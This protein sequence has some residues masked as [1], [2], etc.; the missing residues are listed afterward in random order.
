M[1]SA[2]VHI[3][4]RDKDR[5]EGCNGAVRRRVDA[6]LH[7]ADLG[8]QCGGIAI[9]DGHTRQL[10][11]DLRTGLHHTVD[12]VDKQQHILLLLIPQVLRQCQA[13]VHGPAAAHGVVA[14]LAEGHGHLVQQIRLH[15]LVVQVAAL[16]GALTYTN[17]YGVGVQTLIH[18]VDQLLDQHR[19]AHAGAAQQ[20]HLEALAHRREKVQHLDACPQDIA[21]N[22]D[23]AHGQRLI[24]DVAGMGRVQRCSVQ[25]I[26]IGAEHVT[27]CLIVIGDLQSAR[28]QID[29]HPALKAACLSA[30]DRCRHGAI[31]LLHL[32]H[33]AHAAGLCIQQVAYADIRPLQEHLHLQA[34][35]RHNTSNHIIILLCRTVGGLHRLLCLPLLDQSLH[36]R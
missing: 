22:H 14:H 23:L 3:I 33:I 32:E 1:H 9:V 28:L 29:G 6:L 20:A 12:V 26:A 36:Q 10:R 30:A 16:A 25:R 34:G 15:H 11:R 4:R 13:R 18:I 27:Q 35:N 8:Q 31:D 7:L 24:V 21:V 17:E 2:V 19:F 5:L